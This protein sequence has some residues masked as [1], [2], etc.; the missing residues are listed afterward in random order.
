MER[1]G[2]RRRAGG[3]LNC[4]LLEP[5]SALVDTGTTFAS[6]E[7]GF[8]RGASLRKSLPSAPPYRIEAWASP[9]GGESTD[10]I[11]FHRL[12]LLWGD[13]CG[14]GNPLADSCARWSANI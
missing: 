10:F 6:G 11:L 1:G 5:G 9:I 2:K 13:F 8:P 7:H 4:R 14:S 12:A 3:G